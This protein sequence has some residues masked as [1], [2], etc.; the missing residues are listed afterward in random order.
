LTPTTEQPQESSP[1]PQADP[2]KRPPVARKMVP[3]ERIIEDA[4]LQVR[5][6]INPA[7]VKKYEALIKE[8]GF[9]DPID[10]FFELGAPI[11]AETK[12]KLADGFHRLAAYRAAGA[13]KAPCNIRPLSHSEAVRFSL[14]RNGHHGEAPTNAEKRSMAEHAVLDAEIGMA[15]DKEIAAMIGC[16]AS[17][18]A[19]ARRGESKAQATAKKAEATVRK[20]QKS[21]PSKSEPKA[22]AAKPLNE[23][24][25]K[26]ATLKQIESLLNTEVIDEP[27]L[28]KLMETK[29][30]QYSWVRRPGGIVN[31]K[32]VSKNG[33]EMFTAKVVVKEI[34]LAD[35]IL[36]SEEVKLG[37]VE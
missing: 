11:T 15:T 4:T 22:P 8:Q 37:V 13:E 3:I 14:Q 27:D 2:P 30:A 21:Q 5:G 10:I 6:G 20:S 18:V 28:L 35:I 19:S 26:A 12:F 36:K 9:M 7:T 31:L 33:R 23:H 32:V 34:G 29:E 1:I 16:S 24:P 17:L 25:T